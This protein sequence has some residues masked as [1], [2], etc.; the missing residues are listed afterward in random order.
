M[1]PSTEASLERLLDALERELPA[2]VE[3]RHRLH[4]SP[5]LAHH[6]QATAQTVEAEG[7]SAIFPES[8]LSPNVADAIARQTGAQFGEALYGDTL[9]PPGSSGSTYLGM[10]QANAE[11]MARG[12]TGGRRGCGQ[13]RP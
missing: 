4:A 8:S 6:E 7:V 13:S 11:A 9:G 12:F 5:E 1:Q 10:E 2:A 3:L